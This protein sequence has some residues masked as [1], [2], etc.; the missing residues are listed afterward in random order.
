MG[1]AT[2]AEKLLLMLLVNIKQEG[3]WN[4]EIW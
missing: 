2:A 3:N 4:S 1:I